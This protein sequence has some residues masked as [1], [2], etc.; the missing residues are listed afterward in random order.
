M[1]EGARSGGCRPAGGLLFPDEARDVNAERLASYI[2]AQIAAGELTEW[3]IAVLAG[4]GEILPFAGMTFRTLER[5]P[6]DRGRAVGRYVVKTVL[7]PRD[8]AIDLEAV[9]YGRAVELSNEKRVAKEKDANDAPDGPEIGQVAVRNPAGYC[10]CCTRYHP[11]KLGWNS[12]FR[13]LAWSSA[14]RI[15]ATDSRCATAS[16]R[17]QSGLRWHERPAHGAAL[18][19]GEAI[20]SGTSDRVWRA[21]VLSTI[22]PV[23]SLAGIRERDGRISVLVETA[24]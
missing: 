11:K 19:M 21:M 1:V 2:R 3:T 5:S 7:A 23:K 15:P 18:E 14:F 22:S 20:A 6:L 13:F 4:E 16:T 12:I 17:L 10:F 24:I 9:Q 8:E